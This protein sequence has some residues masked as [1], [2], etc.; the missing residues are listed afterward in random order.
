MTRI[1]CLCMCVCL[2]IKLCYVKDLLLLVIICEKID[3]V[4]GRE[5]AMHCY[6]HI[7]VAQYEMKIYCDTL[8]KFFK[9]QLK[10]IQISHT[11]SQLNN[12]HTHIKRSTIKTSLYCM[13]FL[14]LLSTYMTHTHTWQIYLRFHSYF[15]NCI[16][17]LCG[18]H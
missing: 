9:S 11:H 18:L 15:T 6:D 17:F 8:Y 3:N 13:S 12:L 14:F 2:R 10:R 5:R 16:T 1:Q 4:T 7:N